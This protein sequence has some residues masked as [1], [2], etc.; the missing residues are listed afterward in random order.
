VANKRPGTAAATAAAAAVARTT[1][2]AA[3]AKSVAAVAD[4]AEVAADVA[5]EGKQPSAGGAGPQVAS[6][7]ASE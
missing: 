3:I 5:H 4:G 7:T 2:A 6:D 1:A